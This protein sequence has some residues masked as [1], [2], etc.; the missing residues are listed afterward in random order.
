[1]STP[2]YYI[3]NGNLSFAD[4]TVFEDIELY[5]HKS[6]KICLIGRNGS[7]KSSLM[8]VIG[9]DYH[10]DSG[11]LYKD[12]SAHIA[13][14]KQDT[15]GNLDIS[16][17]DFVIQ[18][19]P[20]EELKYK[21]DIIFNKLQIDGNKIVSTLSGGQLR[22]ACLAKALVLEPEILLLDEP[23]NHLD[24][25]S[26]E[27]LEE[28]IKSYKGSVICISHDRA[29]LSNV[30]NKLWWIDRGVLR[31]SD[32]GFK[33]FEEWREQVLAYEEAALNKLQKKLNEENIWLSQGVTARRK[34]NQKR[35]S[36]LRALRSQ[37]QNQKQHHASGKQ[38]LEHVTEDEVKKTKFIIEADNISFDYG[39]T[40]IIKDFSLL[41]K[42]G[43]KIGLIGPNGSG[44]STL[45]KLLLKELTPTS[46]KV[47][48]GINLDITY[49]DQNRSELNPSHSL[50]TTICP[51][52]GDQVFLSNNR[53]MH[54]ASY[55]KNFM[56][57]PKLLDAKVSTLSGGEA[58]RLLLAKTLINPGNLLLLDEP[59]ND[60]DLDTLEI[61]IEILSDY[62]GTALIVSHDR[63]FL[64]RLV[65]RSLVFTEQGKIADIVGGYDDYIKKYRKEVAAP[66]RPKSSENK[67]TEKREREPAPSNKLTYRDSRL[68]VEIPKQIEELEKVIA[69]A[70]SELSNAALYRSNP[71]KFNDLTEKLSASKNK[72]DE[73]T[74]IWIEIEEK[75]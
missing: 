37:M 17:Y 59:T 58:S 19:L 53:T 55:L 26:I 27:W 9:G 45:I 20:N 64:E 36:D 31:R 41:V 70:E 6:D 12:A 5:L 56:F 51:T 22:R 74:M 43:E 73:L 66:P 65:M 29:F 46:G 40:S 15:I 52:G 75:R 1:M 8:K 7:G 33:Y 54:V 57:H 67:N 49:F 2:I 72:I 3:K 30:T 4:K 44:K 35:L 61:L 39:N 68:L 21:V 16:V 62:Q 42:K 18:D 10:L 69:L 34:R 63:D 47:K 25:A 48:H 50:K 23:T 11:E 38:K 24:I 28:Y 13:Y 71:L 60:L 32:K 14:L